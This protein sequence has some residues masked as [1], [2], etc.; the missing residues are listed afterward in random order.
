M[1]PRSFGVLATQKLF[2]SY[3]NGGFVILL[4]TLIIINASN[5][6]L[7]SSKLTWP[8]LKSQNQICCNICSQVQTYTARYVLNYLSYGLNQ[9]VNL[10]F[11]TNIIVKGPLFATYYGV[12][13]KMCWDLM[14]NY[15]Q[16]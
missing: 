2:C 8:K 14:K 15:L 11:A 3:T 9:H 5:I 10:L 7:K 12:S 1:Q 13:S 16:A 6:L 4:K